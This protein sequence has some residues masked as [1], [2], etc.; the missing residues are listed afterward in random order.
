MYLT[1]ASTLH[2]SPIKISL[3]TEDLHSRPRR[4]LRHTSQRPVFYHAGPGLGEFVYRDPANLTD[5]FAIEISDAG[6]VIRLFNPDPDTTYTENS[7]GTTLNRETGVTS[8]SPRSIYIA[9]VGKGVVAI[10]IRRCVKLRYPPQSQT[11]SNSPEPSTVC[12][13]RT[14]RPSATSQ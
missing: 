1:R 12:K 14:P 9:A 10:G 8:N 11:S 13:L 4:L 3:P 6:E 7:L 5:D 2:R